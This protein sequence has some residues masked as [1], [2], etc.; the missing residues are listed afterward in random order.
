VSSSSFGWLQRGQQRSVVSAKAIERP[1]ITAVPA[2]VDELTDGTERVELFPLPRVFD[3]FA[4]Q[5]V[6]VEALLQRRQPVC[7]F[8]QVIFMR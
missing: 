3:L 4:A 2:N 5:Q 6:S 1:S 8:V 7:S